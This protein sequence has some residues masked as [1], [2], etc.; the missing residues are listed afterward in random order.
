[1]PTH[2]SNHTGSHTHHAKAPTPRLRPAATLGKP[3]V[4]LPIPHGKQEERPPQREERQDRRPL[5]ESPKSHS[6]SPI[7]HERSTIVNGP[8][9]A[10]AQEAAGRTVSFVAIEVMLVSRRESARVDL[11]SAK[12]QD[13]AAHAVRLA[14]NL[15]NMST[16][17]AADARTSRG[18]AWRA[19]LYLAGWL[20]KT[21]ARVCGPKCKAVPIAGR[22]LVGFNQVTTNT[23]TCTTE[24]D[25][26]EPSL[27]THKLCKLCYGGGLVFC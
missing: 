21:S 26:P 27:S 12:W 13:K 9:P 11:R 8:D 16:T 5:V 7:T 25:I 15:E 19:G 14:W 17:P 2:R 20:R 3:R 23:S 18:H 24:P 4:A 10:H 1:M 6:S 22:R